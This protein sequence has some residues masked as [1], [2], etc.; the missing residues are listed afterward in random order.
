MARTKRMRKTAAPR[1]KNISTR[2]SALLQLPVPSPNSSLV[3]ADMREE[4]SKI[5][6]RTPRSKE[7][8]QAFIA[9]KLQILRT[10]P[11]FDLRAR[12]VLAAQFSSRLGKALA[13]KNSGPVP[14]GVGYGAF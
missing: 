7:G 5:T 13:K 8:Q 1:G 9:G 3:V 10:H 4:F 11:A 14:G 12:E 6:D 2:A